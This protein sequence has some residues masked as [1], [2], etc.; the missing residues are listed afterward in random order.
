MHH[1]ALETILFPVKNCSS[2]K[3]QASRSLVSILL[4]AQTL[5]GLEVGVR[6]EAMRVAGGAIV[7][8]FDPGVEFFIFTAKARAT[9]ILPSLKLFRL[10]SLL[11]WSTLILEWQ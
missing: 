8:L 6:L 11:D 10:N 9:F 1:G 2:L 4:E 3:N 5:C 7:P